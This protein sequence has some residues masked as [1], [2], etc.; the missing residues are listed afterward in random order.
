MKYTEKYMQELF[1]YINLELFD[2]A[3][4]LPE[5]MV[6]SKKQC[7]QI[8]PEPI[9]G[10]CVP[11][12]DTYIIGIHKGLSKNEFFDTMVHEMIHI[13]LMDKNGYSGHGKPFKKWCRKAI[14]TFYWKIL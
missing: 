3:L 9:D 14:N 7:K 5:F 11:D 4:D 2:L 10:I 8:W 12:N 1:D 13:K 6:M